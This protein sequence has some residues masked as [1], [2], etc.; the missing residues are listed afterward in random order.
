MVG[1]VVAAAAVVDGVP[2]PARIVLHGGVVSTEQLELSAFFLVGLLGGAHC[3]GM[4]GPLVTM[5]AT[6]FGADANG[7]GTRSDGG[8]ASFR[9]I[10]QHLL[11]NAGRTVSYALL[12]GAFGLAGALFYD[13]TATVLAVSG[14][15]QAVVGLAVGVAI[16]ATGVRYATGRTGGHGGRLAFPLVS[17]VSA[18]FARLQ[19]RLDDWVGGPGVAVLGA[20]HGLLP[21]PLLYPAYLYA[22]ARG[23]PVGGVLTLG[24]LG[25]GTFPTLFAYGTVLESIDATHR[26]RVH[27]ALGVAFVVLGVMPI[28]HSLALFGIDVP[29]VEP[30]YYQPIVG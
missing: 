1:E 5:Y 24:V 17:R 9:E 2:S 22:F 12:G 27:R 10:R 21:C 11:F 3:L 18:V 14:W 29:H 8:L 15:L 30:P 28:S 7:S 13:A 19:S 25:V 6:E 4:C 16:V 23:D 26:R 20:V